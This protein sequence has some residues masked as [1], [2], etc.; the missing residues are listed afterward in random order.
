MSLC[1]LS[2]VGG[3]NRQREDALP[4]EQIDTVAGEPSPC[5]R[6][7]QR[8]SPSRCA[9]ASFGGSHTS[10]AFGAS[11]CRALFEEREGKEERRVVEERKN[12]N[13]TYM[14]ALTYF[15]IFFDD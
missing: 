10:R 4:A 14:W 6:C 8:S 15:L 3:A 11:P 9:P 7:G 1:I 2:E 12:R 13:A 5:R